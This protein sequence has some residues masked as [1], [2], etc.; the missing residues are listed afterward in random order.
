MFIDLLNK[1]LE[2]LGLERRDESE[3][4]G[5]ISTIKA[6]INSS[7]PKTSI[8]KESITSIKRILEGAAGSIVAVELLKYIPP[9]LDKLG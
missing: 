3:I 7:R 4:K 1:R 8:L 9:I 5:D 2:E 6:Q